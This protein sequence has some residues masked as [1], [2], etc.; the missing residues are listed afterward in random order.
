MIPKINIAII[1]PLDPFGSKIGGIERHIEG[2]IK[3]APNEFSITL[4]GCTEDKKSRPVG[5]FSEM[6][7]EG[8]PFFYYPVCWIKDPN[9]RALL[10]HTLAHTIGLL[11][12]R[13]NYAEMILQFHRIE[14]SIVSP[15]KNKRVLFVHGDISDFYDSLNSSKW[16]KLPGLY[17][18]IERHLIKRMTKVFVQNENGIKFYQKTYPQLSERFVFFPS[19]VD[20][21]VFYPYSKDKKMER[22]SSFLEERRLPSSTQIILFVGR[23]ELQKDPM[24]LMETFKYIHSKDEKTTLVIIGTGFLQDHMLEYTKRNHL[25]DHAIFLGALPQG[26]VAGIMRI[27]DVF[28]MTSSFEGMPYAVVE[29]LA[30][31]LPAVSTDVGSVSKAIVDSVSGRLIC[32][33]APEVIGDAVLSVVKDKAIYTP[34]KCNSAIHSFTSN[35]VLN[36]IYRFYERFAFS[37][38]SSAS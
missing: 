22:K 13:L 34:E 19:W 2:F 24:L 32:S 38:D 26:D 14:P 36:D 5:R 25:E 33:R 27:S 37:G 21:A 15:R 11:R 7:L 9:R 1:H 35:K 10:P 16:A 28:L 18:A 6:S 12:Q 30:S 20:E 31:G 4:V 23:L 17:F 29:A 3:K 8:R